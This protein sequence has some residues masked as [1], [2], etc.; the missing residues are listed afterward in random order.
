[1]HFNNLK[2]EPNQ[3]CVGLNEGFKSKLRSR[4]RSR[5]RGSPRKPKASIKRVPKLS[6]AE[7][8]TRYSLG[9]ALLVE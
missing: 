2:I 6:E 4:S 1:M 8:T 3:S 5:S 9:D 7:S